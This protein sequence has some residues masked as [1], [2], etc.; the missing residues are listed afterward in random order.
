ME[1]STY[2]ASG[3]VK[4]WSIENGFGFISVNNKNDI[5]ISLDVIQSY[6]FFRLIENTLI[7]VEAKENDVKNDIAISIIAV[8]GI[9]K[10]KKNKDKFDFENEE[11]TVEGTTL[12]KLKWYND[13]KGFGYMTT[14]EDEKDLWIHIS[15]LEKSNIDTL[16]P[17]KLYKIE[18]GKNNKGMCVSSIQEIENTNINI[19]C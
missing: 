13:K 11:I 10:F 2:I 12:A 4:K 8:A 6:G 14:V 1:N 5:F 16:I 15:I 18:Y 7:T 9:P 3:I 17:E 19:N